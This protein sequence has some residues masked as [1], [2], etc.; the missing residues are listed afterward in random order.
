MNDYFIYSKLQY[1]YSSA[2]GEVLNV[3]LLVLF[4]TEW[5]FIY[6]SK[7]TRLKFLYP[8]I[9]E[10]HI[11]KYLQGFAKQCEKLNK[12]MHGR[13][14]FEYLETTDF[15][16]KVHESFL[17]KNDT[18]LQFSEAKTSILYSPN[19]DKI[20]QNLYQTYFFS[21]EIQT[22]KEKRKDEQQVVK[23]LKETLQEL[24]QGI[25]N[26]YFKHQ[27]SKKI[28]N[29]KTSLKIDLYW[30]NGQ[31]HLVHPLNFNLKRENSI[32]NKAN[33]YFGKFTQLQQ[34]LEAE[35]YIIDIPLVKPTQ[36]HLLKYY[37]RAKNI[38]IEA[39]F[40]NLIEEERL[41]EYA[42]NTIQEL[43]LHHVS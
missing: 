42:K 37:E 34:E 27:E 22:I 33:R 31:T 39:P 21:Y 2:L 8:D 17:V 23:I 19:I 38:L 9:D 35:Q 43:T 3:G 4:P 41:Q 36:K 26:R 18:A 15:L 28:A 6:P 32:D 14:D 13:I 5:R 11:K 1:R 7:L 16:Q 24:N 25:Y 12:G 30:K 10:N 20:I 29:D 40:T